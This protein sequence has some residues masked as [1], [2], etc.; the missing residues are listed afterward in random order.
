MRVALSLPKGEN[1]GWTV[2]S[3]HLREELSATSDDYNERIT[4]NDGTPLVFHEPMI[5]AIQGTSMLPLSLTEW[6]RTRN[7]GLCFIEESELVKRFIPNAE[8]YFDHVCAGSSWNRDILLNAGLRNV[9]VAIQ[10]VDTKLFCPSELPLPEDKFVIFSGGKIEWRKGTDIA[11]K[12]IGVMMERHKDVYCAAAWHNPWQHSMDT[13]KDSTLLPSWDGIPYNAILAAGI[14]IGRLIGPVLSPMDHSCTPLLYNQANIGLF[15]NRIEG[16]TN[17][18]MCEFMACGKPVISMYR[19]GHK[20]VVDEY[21]DFTLH[22]ITEG[23]SGRTIGNRDIEIARYWEP[24]I[25]EVIGML[26]LAYQNRGNK[27]LTDEGLINRTFMK[28]F[29]WTNFAQT[30]LKACQA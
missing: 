1:T 5:H 21:S 11:M 18:V 20:D 10:G 19:H 26:E 25:D 24:Q 12:A 7:V 9:S 22:T 15:P 23:V 4:E 14:D 8:R 29:T 17:M 28:G 3:N 13:M 2:C 6:S 30:L 16:G 27:Q